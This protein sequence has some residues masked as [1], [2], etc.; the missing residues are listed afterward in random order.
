VLP[1]RW[2]CSPP[3]RRTMTD[4]GG[5]K[6]L[7]LMLAR[8]ELRTTPGLK[9]K[10]L[11]RQ[12][13]QHG[14]L[15]NRS[16]L[17]SLLHRSSA[18]FQEPPGSGQWR[19]LPEKPEP[20]T[21]PRPSD[22]AGPKG[23]QQGTARPAY[24]PG[25][26]ERCHACGRDL[27][28]AHFSSVWVAQPLCVGCAGIG[29]RPRPLGAPDPVQSTNRSRTPRSGAS[30]YTEEHEQMVYITAGG[31]VWHLDENCSARRAG[32]AESLSM[33]HGAH[34]VRLVPLRTVFP[35]RR[36]CQVCT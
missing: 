5:H 1:T 30:G 15:V 12:L 18:F 28:V 2:S 25:E 14:I 27:P 17:S 9:A 7:I 16:D 32:Q 33:G 26:T 35:E 13:A 19:A 24:D 22:S 10:E 34:R 23:Q 31:S 4:P 3:H 11:R 21:T 36:P 20:A 29:R 6:A 8:R